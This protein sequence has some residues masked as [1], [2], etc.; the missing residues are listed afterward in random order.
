MFF[1]KKYT[2]TFLNSKWEI[3]KSNVKLVSIPNR[4]EY[5]YM[6][7]RYYDVLN[8]VHT[9]DKNHKILIIIEESKVKIGLDL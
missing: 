8:V 7:N 6:D 2:V 9:I 3:V 5:I 4:N 1:S